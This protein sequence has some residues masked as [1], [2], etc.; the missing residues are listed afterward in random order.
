MRYIYLAIGIVAEVFGTT[1]LKF[2]DNFTKLKPSL[3][4]AACYGT[5]LFMLSKVVRMMPVAI[6]YAIWSGAGIVLVTILSA[7]WLRQKL[8]W[9]ALIGIALIVMGVVIVNLFS[10]TLVH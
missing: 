8:D 5:S 10:K 9:P 4:V 3:V 1:L 2:T 7:V 6:V